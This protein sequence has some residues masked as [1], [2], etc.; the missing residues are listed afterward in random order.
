MTIK[1]NKNYAVLYA[2]RKFG[3]IPGKK[4]LHKIMYFAGLKANIYTFQ[5]NKFGPY[6]EELTYDF[7]DGVVEGLI[8]V[9]PTNLKSRDGKQYNMQLSHHGLDTL[10]SFELDE[11]TK[12]SIDFAYKILVEKS[13][14]KMELLAS[15]YYIVKHDDYKNSQS[16]V[17]ETLKMLKPRAGFTKEEVTDSIHELQSLSLI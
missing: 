2:I 14:R 15:T 13:P 8:D 4:A 3:S 1:E 12:R 6:S 5:W 11:V 10:N 16:D 7:D 9:N 17:Y